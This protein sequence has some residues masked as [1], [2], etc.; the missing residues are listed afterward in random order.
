MKAF[1]AVLIFLVL[2]A[3]AAVGYLYLTANLEVRFDN[4]IATDGLT[5][6]EY[7]DGLKKRWKPPP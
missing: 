7:F 5:Q 2:L 4:C 1:A 6:A 3:V